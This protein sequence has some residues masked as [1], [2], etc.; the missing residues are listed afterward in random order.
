MVCASVQEDNPRALETGLS[1][2][3]T[4]NYTINCFLHLHAFALLHCA[5]FDLNIGLTMKRA[6]NMFIIHV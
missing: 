3:P 6:I 5:I 4:Q 1:P 2:I